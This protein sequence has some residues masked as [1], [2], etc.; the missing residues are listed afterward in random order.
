MK[1][2]LL[3]F[4]FFLL[5]FTLQAQNIPIDFE[6]DDIEYVWADF[7]GGVVTIIDNPDA[8]GINTSDKVAQ[9]VKFDG[10]VFGG[11]TLTIDGPIDF[12]D[13][14][15][16]TMKVWANRVGAPVLFKLEGAAPVEVSAMTTVA[17][18][19]EELTF[20][21]TG[22]TGATYTAITIIYDLGTVGDGSAD[23]TLYFDD[24]EYSEGDGVARPMIPIDFESDE[25]EYVWT[26]FAGGVAT[27]I[28]NPDASGINTSDKVGQMVKF[29]GEVFGG[30]TLALGGAVD[31]GDNTAISMKVWANRVGAPVLFKLEGPVPVE[32]NMMTTVA[33]EWEELTFDFT[34]LTGATYT[35]ITIIYDLGTVG[36]G[37]ADFTLYFDDIQFAEGDGVA[38]PTLPIGFESDDIEYVWSDFGGGVATVIDNPDASG[39]NTSDKVGQMVKFAGEVFGGSTLALG[40]AIDFGTNTMISMKTWANRVGAPIL[41][42]LE[43]PAPVEVNMMSTV[44][45]EW[46]VLT[47]DF[48]GL[49]AGTYTGITIIY[50]LGTAGDGSADFTLYFDDIAIV[51]PLGIRNFADLEIGMYPNPAADHLTLEAKNTIDRVIVYNL[52]GQQVLEVQPARTISTLDL[53]ALAPGTYALRVLSAGEEAVAKFV[54]Q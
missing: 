31:F 41:L 1:Y 26:D 29:D 4:C 8:S 36:D 13:N 38:R 50:D 6:S 23:F 33:N 28:D 17:N 32:V 27:I 2:T 18:E 3:T 53:S 19:W 22:L 12:G 43:G 25:I 21:F 46:E 48:D 11:S 49:T 24:M 10:E 52:M 16:I 7:A 45:N 20:D 30:S 42:K 47:F 15:A 39:I 51:D 9:M 5:G 44:A 37:S 54:K 35:G 34:G 14:S 40:G